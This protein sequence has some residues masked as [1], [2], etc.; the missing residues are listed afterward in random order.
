M[1]KEKYV[2]LFGNYYG[3]VGEGPSSYY[4]KLNDEY[5]PADY[6]EV[7]EKFNE[8]ERQQREAAVHNLRKVIIMEKVRKSTFETNSSSSHSIVVKDLSPGD[9]L[10]IGGLIPNDEGVV[11]LETDDYGWQ[12]ERIRSSYIKACYL[13][14]YCKLSDM[15]LFDRLEEVIKDVTGAK[16]VIIQNLEEL[17][18]YKVDEEVFSY[19]YSCCSIDH[20]SYNVPYN[21]LI[22]GYDAIKNFIFNPESILYLGNDN[23]DGV[24]ELMVEDGNAEPYEY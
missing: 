7:N 3:K 15:E 12:V 17:E 16:E 23:D 10:E 2:Y 21:L 1:K 4:Y 13:A 22:Q 5:F 9:Y 24:H 14:T 11:V 19:H 8:L 6:I 20:Q 18:E